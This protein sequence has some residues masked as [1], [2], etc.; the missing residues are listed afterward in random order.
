[1]CVSYRQRV[2]D[3]EALEVDLVGRGRRLVPLHDVLRQGGEVVP[4]HAT[5]G[6][7]MSMH[8]PTNAHPPTN[9]DKGTCFIKQCNG[10][11]QRNNATHPA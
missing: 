9:Q 3:D 10:K 7:K 8:E 5:R 11:T 1:M 4:V 2:P 6:V